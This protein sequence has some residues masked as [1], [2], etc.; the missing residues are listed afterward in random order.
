MRSAAARS[1]RAGRP[2]LYADAAD[3]AGGRPGAGGVDDR[4]GGDPG[5]GAV[6]VQDMDR[7]RLPLAVRVDDAVTAQTGDAGDTGACADLVAED[8]GQRLEVARG[9]VPAGGVRGPVGGGPAGRC[10]QLFGR[11]VDQLGP[12]GEQ[13]DVAPLADGGA[14]GLAGFEN[15]GLDV[16]LQQVSGGGESDGAGSDDDDRKL[17]RAHVVSPR[18]EFGSAGVDEG[19]ELCA[20]PMGR[21]SVG[22]VDDLGTAVAEADAGQ[23]TG[24]APRLGGGESGADRGCHDNPLIR[25]LSIHRSLPLA[26][27]AVNIDICR[28]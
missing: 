13:P 16:A 10:E 22:A 28:I 5:F 14:C 3:R 4:A 18:C 1:P 6:G 8:V 17:L 27:T 20:L 2:S 7:E 21:R 11:R 12:G 25:C 24:G 23:V 26:S 15:Q 9:P 19:G